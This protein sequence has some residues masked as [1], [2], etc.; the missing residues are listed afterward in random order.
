MCRQALHRLSITLAVV[1]SLLFSQLALAG[2]VCPAE[3]RAQTMA[4]MMAA[5]EPC[6]G[7][8][9]IQPLLCHQHCAAAA[10][11]FE[12]VKLPTATLPALLQMI[13]LPLEADA[14]ATVDLPTGAM[15]DARRWPPPVFLAT[16]RLRV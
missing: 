11:S 5:G 3:G 14:G 10:Q 8:D 7:M 1:V 15:V 2:Y 6:N 13:V 16:L 12:L 4:R 9:E